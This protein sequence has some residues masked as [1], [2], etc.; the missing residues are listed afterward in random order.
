MAKSERCKHYQQNGYA[1]VP[2]Q[3][4]QHPFAQPVFIGGKGSVQGIE[5]SVHA[6]SMLLE[7]LN[8]ICQLL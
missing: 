1:G 5:I 7:L 4:C 6:G 3:Q 8:G 2:D